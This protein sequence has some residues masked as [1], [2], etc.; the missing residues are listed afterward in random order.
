VSAELTVGSYNLHWGRGHRWNRYPTFDVLAAARTIDTDVLVFQ[1]CWLPDDGE[2]DVTAVARAL[3][4]ELHLRPLA[5][6][7]GGEKPHVVALADA[8]DADEHGEGLWALA[9]LSRLPVR[10]VEHTQLPQLR[11]DPSNRAVLR[12]EVELADG[13]PFTV[14]GTHMAHLEKGVFLRRAPFRAALPADDVPALV[15]GDMN[16]WSW[17]ISYMAPSAWTRV[18]RGRTFSSRTPHS[19]IDH[20]VVSPPV[21]AVHTEVLPNL[22]S[23]HLPIRGRFRVR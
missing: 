18:G 6:S 12:V 2:A 21:E 4:Y 23:D 22:G 7:T 8:P 5:R 11:F 3:G 15:A 10:S 16:M 1:E 19:R 9:V 20:F 17:A 14:C 13:T